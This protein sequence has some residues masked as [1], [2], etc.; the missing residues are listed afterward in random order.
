M[1]EMV[2][3]VFHQKM[4]FF[5]PPTHEPQS[6]A[7]GEPSGLSKWPFNNTDGSESCESTDDILP[8]NKIQCDICLA[9]AG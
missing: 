1:Q 4:I 8:L 2:N 3:V 9:A 6:P 7:P 5:Y